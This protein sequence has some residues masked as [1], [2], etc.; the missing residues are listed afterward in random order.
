MSELGNKELAAAYKSGIKAAM[1]KN[2][3]N[4]T[5]TQKEFIDSYNKWRRIGDKIS[6]LELQ[7]DEHLSMGKNPAEFFKAKLDF[8]FGTAIL[9]SKRDAFLWAMDNCV[10]WQFSKG[11]YRR[12]FHTH[13]FAFC[14]SSVKDIFS[15]FEYCA[16]DCDTVK[17]LKVGDGCTEEIKAYLQEQTSLC[18]YEIAYEIEKGNN[19]VIEE[20]ENIIMYDG[21]KKFLGSVISAVV[22]T[23][24]SRLLDDLCKLLLAAQQ[25]E[26]LRQA[27]CE[28]A[29]FGTKKA[30]LTI[31][32]TIEEN[33]LVRFSSV[34]R[35]I[36]VWLGYGEDPEKI[37]R[38][39]AKLLQCM[40]LCVTDTEYRK[41]CLE[42]D[43]RLEISVALWSEGFDDIENWYTSIEKL[44]K[45][46]KPQLIT[47]AEYLRMAGNVKFIS[48]LSVNIICANDDDEVLA[49]FIPLALSNALSGVNSYNMTFTESKEQ[50]AKR[51]FDSPDDENIAAL[52]NKLT[53][54]Y[55]DLKKG[56]PIDKS[57]LCEKILI[58]AYLLGDEKLDENL[59]KLK[60]INSDYR[61]SYVFLLLRNPNTKAQLLALTS[62]LSD[63]ADYVRTR[64]LLN[65][66]KFDIKLDD[67]C[68]KIVEDSL[69]YKNEDLRKTAISVLEK[70]TPEKIKGTVIRLLSGKTEQLRTAAL[71]I[72][73]DMKN[74]DNEELKNL[75]NELSPI[76]ADLENPTNKE[77]VLLQNIVTQKQ[78][79]LFTEQDRNVALSLPDNSYTH[80]A[81]RYFMSIFP[82]SDLGRI[83]YPEEYSTLKNRILDKLKDKAKGT[84][85]GKKQASEHCEQ[86][87]EALSL[88]QSLD[89][90]MTS[91][92]EEEFKVDGEFVTIPTC[93]NYVD[94]YKAFED[95]FK[96]WAEK[97]KLDF[98]K[99]LK[100]YVLMAGLIISP[101]MDNGFALFFEPIMTSLF[102][103]G[104][105]RYPENKNTYKIA[106]IVECLILGILDREI[107]QQKKSMLETAAML[108]ILK[109]DTEKL[110]YKEKYYGQEKTVIILNHPQFDLL[111]NKSYADEHLS[112]FLHLRLLVN[113]KLNIGKQLFWGGTFSSSFGRYTYLSTHIDFRAFAVAAFKGIIPEKAFYSLCYSMPNFITI[114][115]NVKRGCESENVTLISE[116]VKVK[117]FSELS[118]EQKALLS[119]ICKIYD[120]MTEDMLKQET[121]RGESETDY[122]KIISRFGVIYGIDNYIKLLKA[123]GDDTLAINSGYIYDYGKKSCQS[124]LIGICKPLPTDTATALKTAAKENNIKETR[125]IEAALYSPE[126]IELT[127]QVLGWEGFVSGCS[128]FIAHMNEYQTPKRAALI[129][130]FTPLTNLQLMGGAFDKNWFMSVYNTL[131]E[132]RFN[133]IYKGA[134]YI[135]DG[136]K[137]TRARKYADAALGRLDKSQVKA[138]I[139]DK[140]NKDLLMAYG[141]I[142]IES[143][144]DLL[145]RYLFIQQ[146]LKES[147]KFGAQRRE[148]EKTASENALINL[149]QTCGFDNTTRLTLK[150][151]S[152]L[153]DKNK[154]LFE[155]V[156]I[157]DVTLQLVVDDSG[158]A[159]ITAIKDGKKL[160]SIPSKLNKNEQ[161][162][163]LKD[164]KKEMSQQYSRTKF[165]LEN[166]MENGTE[167]SAEEISWLMQNPV[168][169]PIASSLVFLN[170]GN[171]GF[172]EDFKLNSFNNSSVTLQK[173]DKLRVAH[174]FMLY[175]AGIWAEYQRYLFDKKLIQPF[176]QV[177][178]ELYVKTDE[179]LET[180]YSRRYSGNQI[181]PKKALACLKTRGWI[182]DIENGLQKIYY[183]DDIVATIYALADWF[184]PADIECPTLE[185]VCFYDR[186]KGT[187]KKIEEI[188]DIIFSEVMRDV[189]LC[190]SVAHAGGVDPETSHSTVEM[191]KAVAMLTV[192]LFGFEN[193]SF[194]DH[195]AR[196]KGE[197]GEYTVHLG[198]GICHKQSLM[199]NI[200][201]VHSQQRGKLFLPFADEDPKT[202]EIISKILLLAEDKKIKDPQI[203]S[204]IR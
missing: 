152:L 145:E 137:H 9:Q 97:E 203:I 114:L 92:N 123:L 41:Q 167:F 50:Y 176:K 10:N 3:A 4:L 58:C 75:Y 64:A 45:G 84:L 117:D 174:P 146:F 72:I 83:V 161:V 96:A 52:Y 21:D 78:E 53:S 63:K 121:N 166:A 24:N 191:R 16:V 35:A 141:I 201:P 131:G 116:V 113:N 153:A 42:G 86:A 88:V 37:E 200:L 192:S 142:P 11:M 196:I 110:S 156:T 43:N 62:A 122:S 79:K 155:P 165:M 29:D 120:D 151:E 144:D 128:Y 91:L 68:Y 90:L 115:S 183:K 193:V 188:P 132:K 13:S 106:G 59:P 74:S 46:S 7:L 148:S 61:G 48:S 51:W 20:V 154:S 119:Y 15:S 101:D 139:A 133:E 195:H 38:I 129:A 158:K 1:D 14:K 169:K 26:G 81:V 89:E 73:I 111:S 159:D 197:Y 28:A 25:Q 65:I 164:A 8:V 5:D 23:S 180:P 34:K 77:K 179:E 175:K 136:N 60:E 112:E 127:E 95:K 160:K 149:A 31:L 190:V 124:Y 135:T 76:A 109:T 44:C 18:P 85:Q 55:S 170:D 102:G 80:D 27:I 39:S 22:L 107:V 181:Q 17:Q 178:R 47:A 66:E 168:T 32:K 186:I 6:E 30:F 99:A 71:S 172:F 173:S 150:M 19:E 54:V 157:D 130:R 198:S 93:R 187:L 185:Y 143:D 82:S 69:R 105:E 134:K 33:N 163:L 94:I 147:K 2:I 103:S 184:S 12:A 182:A 108:Y 40:I 189:D 171:F 56:S 126:W 199:I 67:D 177:F 57:D 202:A 204:Q 162:L 98:E 104:F 118:D 49:R 70:Q 140:R 125:L 100:L 36:G 194:S 87:K 138:Q